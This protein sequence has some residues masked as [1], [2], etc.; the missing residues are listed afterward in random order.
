[1]LYNTISD[2]NSCVTWME[3][4]G[5]K[6]DESLGVCAGPLWEDYCLRKKSLFGLVS[7]SLD[8]LQCHLSRFLATTINFGHLETRVKTDT[9]QASKRGAKIKFNI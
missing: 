3:C 4:P 8:A 1:M 9:Y 7:A 2:Q 6:L 5:F